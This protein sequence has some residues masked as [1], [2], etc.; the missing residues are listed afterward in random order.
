MIK[1]LITVIVVLCI[2]A[3]KS[4]I[5][6]IKLSDADYLPLKVGT[7]RQYNIDSILY[8]PFT[9]NA[10]SVHL[11]IQEQIVEKYID[12][13]NDSAFRLTWSKYDSSRNEWKVFKSF[14]R[15]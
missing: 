6:E 9:Q 4:S 13:E 1:N 11:D 2:S 15:K 7:V 10:D 5:E 8:N 12:A 14:S 3:C